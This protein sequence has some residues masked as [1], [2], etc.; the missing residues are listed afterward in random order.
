MTL[1]PF[2]KKGKPQKSDFHFCSIA[3][4]SEIKF[5]I[6][7]IRMHRTGLDLDFS[8]GDSLASWIGQLCGAPVTPTS[9]HFQTKI[10]KSHCTP[11]IFHHCTH[12]SHITICLCASVLNETVLF[13]RLSSSLVP[14]CLSNNR[15]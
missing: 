5:L 1:V 3:Q 15:S 12:H 7:E 13:R 14:Q 9:S 2:I 10:H 11:F 4:G 6:S 8:T